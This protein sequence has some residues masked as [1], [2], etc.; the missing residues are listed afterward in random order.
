M[1]TTARIDEL[2]KK[3][4]ENPRRYFAPLANELRKAGDLVQAIALCREHLPRQ[5]GHMSGYIVLGQALY[6]AGSL[7]EA[8]SVFEQA[9]ALDPENLIALRHLGDI[10]KASGD[11][12]TA[13]RWYERVLDADPRNDDIAAQLDALAA[14]PTPVRSLPPVSITY[15]PT[16][17]VPQTAIGL[18]AVPTPDASLRAVDFDVVNARMTHYEPLDLDALE[19]DSASSSTPASLTP[20]SVAPVAM[21]PLSSAP[22]APTPNSFTPVSLTPIASPA[23]APTPLSFTPLSVTPLSVTPLSVT[24]LSVTPLSVTPLSVTALSVPV[25]TP[26]WVPRVEPVA[27]DDSAAPDSVRSGSEHLDAEAP[28]L[29]TPDLNASFGPDRGEATPFAA[30]IGESQRAV[31]DALGAF[32]AH[33]PAHELQS[34]HEVDSANTIDT[35]RDDDGETRAANLQGVFGAMAPDGVSDSVA[36]EEG[37]LAPEW[38]DTSALVARVFTPRAVTPASVEI[39]SEA[40]D[41]FGREPNEPAIAV[42]VSGNV[43]AV[44]Q[45]Q[46]DEAAV[47]SNPLAGWDDESESPELSTVIN[48]QDLPWLSAPFIDA[49]AVV[50]HEMEAIADAFAHDAASVGDPADVLV[51]SVELESGAGDDVSFADVLDAPMEPTL[52]AVAETWPETPVGEVNATDDPTP[53]SAN[54]DKH[55]S[56]FYEPVPVRAA[57]SE[58]SPAFVTETM[59]ELLVSQGFIGRAATIYEELVR[60]HPYDAVLTSRLDEL[61]AML[62]TS[63]AVERAAESQAAASALRDAERSDANDHA[64]DAGQDGEERDKESTWGPPA[65]PTPGYAAPAYATPAFGG[66]AAGAAVS[67]AR[68]RFA[69]LAAR[70][71]PRRTPSKPVA[72]VADTSNGLSALFG[73]APTGAGDDAAARALADAFAPIDESDSAGIFDFGDTESDRATRASG[74]VAAIRHSDTATTPT[75]PAFSFDRF[76]PDPAAAATAPSDQGSTPPPNAPVGEDLAQF[77]AWLKGLGST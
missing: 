50:E 9:L 15:A 49:D 14:V 69:Q 4:D 22:V 18:G 5:P 73:D 17:P 46:F 2:R 32:A 31:D 16:P 68:E 55:D 27:I 28:N 38:P 3:F 63:P 65:Y 70:R 54:H 58:S 52:D 20:I 26:T 47:A 41:A 53:I 56:Q 64:D 7:E 1:S 57:G 43:E 10:A 76:F 40:V 25:S 42:D 51:S 24:P 29:T 36:F 37:I 74:S 30:A 11:S 44:P 13:R 59:A 34:S 48:E 33:D 75:G 35:A 72:V 8:R 39:T 60:R 71:V 66:S 19:A 21:P 67:T 23:I 45:E 12:A 6:E 61:R 62:D 77:S